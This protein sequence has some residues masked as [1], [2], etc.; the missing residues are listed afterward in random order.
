[1]YTLEPLFAAA[2][3]AVFLGES[4]GM[5]TIIGALCIILACVW[6]A[7]GGDIVAYLSSSPS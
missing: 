1:M 7:L 6:S 2:I 3:S 4:I 5:N